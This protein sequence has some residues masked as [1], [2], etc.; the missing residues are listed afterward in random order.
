MKPAE[1][2]TLRETSNRV[3]KK[4][5]DICPNPLMINHLFFLA[6]SRPSFTFSSI[7]E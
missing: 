3:R 5:S 1:G 2:E 7:S 4:G 6:V